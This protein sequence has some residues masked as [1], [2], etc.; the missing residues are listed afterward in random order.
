MKH[1]ANYILARQPAFYRL[2]L[3][4]V[5]SRHLEKKTFLRL[6][7]DGDVAFD[8]G[9]NKGSYTVLFS[10]IV[11]SRGQVHSF[12]PVRS[13]LDMLKDRL[14]KE[15]RFANVT[16]NQ[17]AMGES[18]G[19]MVMHIP[20]GDHGQASLRRHST[21]SWAKDQTESVSCRV[22]TMDGYAAEKELK[23]LDFIKM[24]IEGAE[25]LALRGGEKTLG[26]FQPVLHLEFYR[27]WTEAFGYGAKELLAPLR[28]L[29]YR[30]FYRGDFTV[31]NQPEEE[32]NATEHSENVICSARPL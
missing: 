24:D 17:A 3:E 29:G 19:E 14:A 16:L 28:A 23:K 15:Q 31:L 25:L 30:N 12:E 20:A 4:V 18:E 7:K 1:H 10:H 11:G 32:L 2:L 9:A 8:I 26:K 5:R 22:K 13:T 6:V 27:S 21:G